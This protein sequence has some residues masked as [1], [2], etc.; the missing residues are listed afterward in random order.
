MDDE[1]F[2]TSC[3]LCTAAVTFEALIE[4]GEL[5]KWARESAQ[6]VIAEYLRAWPMAMDRRHA[7]AL[8]EDA[9]RLSEAA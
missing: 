2:R 9:L 5:P 6:D 1:H 3:A 7:D 8:K 4:R